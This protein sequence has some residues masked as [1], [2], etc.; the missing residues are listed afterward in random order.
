[1]RRSGGAKYE[2]LIISTCG[3]PG[4]LDFCRHGGFGCL[5]TARRLR[6]TRR[7][8]PRASPICAE[9]VFLSLLRARVLRYPGMSKILKL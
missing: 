5:C 1:M 3:R 6:E 4:I 9:L 2:F 8:F 7:R